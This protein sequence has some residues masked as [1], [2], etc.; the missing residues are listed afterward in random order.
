MVRPTFGSGVFAVGTIPA[1]TTSSDLHFPALSG[2]SIDDRLTHPTQVSPLPIG[3]DGS[4][5]PAAPACVLV[6]ACLRLVTS[7]Q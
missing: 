5:P 6:A 2:R 3:S 7:S 4:C 1:M